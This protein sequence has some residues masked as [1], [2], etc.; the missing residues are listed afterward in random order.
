MN[1]MPVFTRL[2]TTVVGE[3]RDCFVKQEM[4]QTGIDRGIKGLIGRSN[5]VVAGYAQN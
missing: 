3:V 4:L 1:R 5:A 2:E